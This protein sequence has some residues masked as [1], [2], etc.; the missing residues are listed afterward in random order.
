M[1]ALLICPYELA[2]ESALDWRLSVCAL[3]FGHEQAEWQEWTDCDVLVVHDIFLGQ[4]K[5][6]HDRVRLG[7]VAGIQQEDDSTTVATRIPFTN[8]PIE[9]ELHGLP[10][11]SWHHGH[12]LFA[13]DASLR[14]KDDD[15][16]SGCRRGGL[17][18]GKGWIGHRSSS[19]QG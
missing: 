18:L 1:V 19:Y 14:G 5:A 8:L 16:A 3:G 2:A 15:H 9:I 7:D 4:R 6:L 12:D 11:F 17:C 10:D 13:C